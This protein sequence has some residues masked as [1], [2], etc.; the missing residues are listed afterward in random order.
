[1]EEN[2]GLKYGDGLFETIRVSKGRI[3]YLEDHFNRLSQGLS[4]LQMQN[5]ESPLL[6]EQFQKILLDFL[7][8]QSNANLRIR[9]TFFRQSGGLYTPQK[10]NYHYFLE[11]QPLEKEYYAYQQQGVMLG[12]SSRVRL[13]MDSL[14]NLKTISALPYVLA[15]IEKKQNGW[16]DCLLLNAEGRVAEAIAANVF[17]V[18]DKNIYTPA[19]SEGCVAGVMR[20]QIIRL[21]QFNDLELFEAKIKLEDLASANEIFLTNAIQGIQPV[22][23][24]AF[25]TSNLEQSIAPLLYEKLLEEWK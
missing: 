5:A 10:Q 23:N 24:L 18:K 1:M 13:A 7:Y 3:L 6:L 15:G 11:A 25:S 16:D 22:A 20:K 12:C 19:L 17:V 2:R 21:A 14:S 9:I 8:K 4:T